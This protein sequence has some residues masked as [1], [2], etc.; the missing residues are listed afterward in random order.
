MGNPDVGIEIH[1]TTLFHHNTG[2]H[3]ARAMRTVAVGFCVR[4]FSQ[5]GTTR[6]VV[7]VGVGYQ[8]MAD[9]FAGQCCDHVADVFRISRTGVDDGDVLRT[10]D[11][12]PGT[13]KGERTGVPGNHPTNAGRNRFRTTIFEAEFSAIRDLDCH[14]RSA[15]WTARKGRQE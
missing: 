10:E 5:Q 7:H 14:L 2:S 8:N 13:M 12:G 6:R 9:T 1:V 15:L 4:K 3:L 11:V